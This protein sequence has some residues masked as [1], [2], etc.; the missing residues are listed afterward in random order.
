MTTPAR[1][2]AQSPQKIALNQWRRGAVATVELFMEKGLLNFATTGRCHQVD[3]ASSYDAGYL[4]IIP[5]AKRSPTGQQG[6]L[7]T[8]PPEKLLK[9]AR[10]APRC[11]ALLSNSFAIAAAKADDQQKRLKTIPLVP[12]SL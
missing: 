8:S 9:C 11:A 4:D 2:P 12:G 6:P 7:T 5:G 3:G 1:R 10:R